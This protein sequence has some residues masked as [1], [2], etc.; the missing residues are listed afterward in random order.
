[1]GGA[2]LGLIGGGLASYLGHEHAK[3]E[4]Q[5]KEGRDFLKK[6]FFDQVEKDPTSLDNADVQKHGAKILGKDLFDT[7]YAGHKPAIAKIYRDRKS[8]QDQAAQIHQLL[9]LPPAPMG[10]G[11]GPTGQGGQINFAP[12]AQGNLSE[13]TSTQ[14]PA[15]A[16][17]PP[18][19]SSTSSPAA[20]TAPPAPSAAPSTAPPA[21]AAPATAPSA[22]PPA[23]AS[24][25]ADKIN[26]LIALRSTLTDSPEDKATAKAIEMTVAHLEK[27]GGGDIKAPA[28]LD[29]YSRA[30]M[31]KPFDQLDQ[32]SQ[33]KALA[34]S[35]KFKE[36][37]AADAFAR[38]DKTWQAR[39][40]DRVKAQEKA[41]EAKDH[42]SALAHATSMRTSISSWQQKADTQARLASGPNVTQDQREAVIANLND[43]ADAKEQ[44]IRDAIAEGT[45][46][47]D[48]KMPKMSHYKVDAKSGGLMGFF[49]SPGT[50]RAEKPAAALTPAAAAP[51]AVSPGSISKSKSGKAIIQAADGTWHYLAD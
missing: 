39:E 42:K 51:P 26:Q 18:G 46:P 30:F 6:A 16:T 21:A 45:L 36:N 38:A 7:Y 12:D 34:E 17:A 14:T 13:A 24:G 8:Q 35:Q 4:Q 33:Q 28:E 11:V 5:D 3:K 9:G 32:Q 29:A 22:Q 1:M 47:P 41:T 31:G 23:S 20:P 19:V 49:Q 44:E 25:H 48:F 10:S 43:E 15:L 37:P 27:I 50:V 40:A 2:V